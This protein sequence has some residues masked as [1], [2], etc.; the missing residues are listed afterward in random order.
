MREFENSRRVMM[1]R[2]TAECKVQML[3]EM[4]AA[5]KTPSSTRNGEFRLGT[6]N[7]LSLTQSE[8]M[9]AAMEAKR[10]QQWPDGR[11]YTGLLPPRTPNPLELGRDEALTTS[12]W[13]SRMFNLGPPVLRA[14]TPHPQ[15]GPSGIARPRELSSRVSLRAEPREL[16]SRVSM[17]S[18]RASASLPALREGMRTPATPAL[19][20]I[21]RARPP[22]QD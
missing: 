5:V 11:S 12:S 19:R 7:V 3:D 14:T 13:A 1:G 17:R 8:R 10:A 15:A 4:R 18:M 22:W 2:L 6:G 21:S 20:P 9:I 16:S